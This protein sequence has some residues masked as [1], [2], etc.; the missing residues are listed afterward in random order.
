MI[1]K[2]EL[3]FNTLIFIFFIYHFCLLFVNGHSS[4]VPP[5]LNMVIYDIPE[6]RTLKHYPIALV[7]VYKC[8]P[9]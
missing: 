5:Q 2:D 3:C 8:R 6:S 9:E 4:M 1:T 7:V